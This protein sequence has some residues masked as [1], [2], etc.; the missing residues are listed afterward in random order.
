[1]EELIKA[2]V[3]NGGSPLTF[4]ESNRLLWLSYKLLSHDDHDQLKHIGF[5]FTINKVTRYKEIITKKWWGL[6]KVVDKQPYF[7]YTITMIGNKRR[8]TLAE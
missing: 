3:A 1:M 8:P 5:S 4:D 6:K 7:V 2:F